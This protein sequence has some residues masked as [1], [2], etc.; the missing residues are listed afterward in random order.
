MYEGRV[1]ISAMDNT[2]QKLN[3]T[4]EQTDRITF[5]IL[6]LTILIGCAVVGL[7]LAMWTRGR[8]KEIAV[9]IS[10]G[11]SKG[12]IFLQMLLEDLFL[13]GLSFIG[14]QMITILLLPVVGGK[15]VYLQGNSSMLQL[16]PSGMIVSLCAG[17]AGV[18]ILMGISIFPYM[19][20]QV[21]EVLSEMEG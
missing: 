6:L 15:M 10:L 19:K 9:L 11:V 3:L 14:A 20:K 13:Y 7:L 17:L 4:I 21:K 2:F 16:S 18:M 8:K 5:M 12:N 1:V